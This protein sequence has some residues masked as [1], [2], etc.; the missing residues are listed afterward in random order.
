MKILHLN[1]KAFLAYKDEV[2]IDFTLDNGLYLINGPTGSGKTTIFD[3]IVFAL[4]GQSSGVRGAGSLRSDFAKAKDETYVEL[5][6]EVGGHE[7]YIKRSPSYKREGLKTAK[8]ATAILKIDDHEYVEG[9]KEVN[10]KIIDIL[11]INYEQFKQIVMISQ[12]EFTKLIYSGSDEREKVLR[13]IFNTESLQRLENVLKDKVR[14]YKEEY[15]VSEK[16]L[17]SSL[18]MLSYDDLEDSF[19]PKMLESIYERIEA[20][21]QDLILLEKEYLDKEKDY[22]KASN[23]YTVKSMMNT[24]IKQLEEHH[25]QYQELMLKEEEI[26][27]LK[28]E[29][30][31]LQNISKNQNNILSYTLA[32]QQYQNNKENYN[33]SVNKQKELSK[34]YEEIKQKY[35][36]LDSSRK[37]KDNLYILVN[38]LKQKIDKK[39]EYQ[40]YNTKYRQAKKELDNI[41]EIYTSKYND[42]EKLNVRMQRDQGKVNELPDLLVELKEMD[43]AVEANNQ[44]RVLIHELSELNDHLK[45]EQEKH[46]MLSNAYNKASKI[47]QKSLEEY[48]YQDELYKRQQA[49]I[50]A[51]TLQD[52]TP[53]PV[54]GS[55]EHPS[56]AKL[57]DE[58]LTASQ[59]NKMSKNLQNLLKEKEDA[60][61]QVVLQNQFKT[62]AL[63]QLDILKKQLNIEG[64]LNKRVFIEQLSAITLIIKEGKKKYQKIFEKAEYLKKLKASLKK[65]QVSLENKEKE[66]QALLEELLDKKKE[67]SYLQAKLEE[68][69]DLF[70]E[71][72]EVRYKETLKRYNSL[73]SL[74]NDIE[75]DYLE[76]EKQMIAID[77]SIEHYHELLIQSQDTL[78]TK[79]EEYN[80]YIQECF[81]NEEEFLKYYEMLDQKD[82]KEKMYQE[83]IINKEKLLSNIE[84]LEKETHNNEYTDLTNL[85]EEVNRLKGE[86]NTLQ[87]NYHQKTITID[88][89]TKIYK[90]LK[91]EYNKNKTIHKNYQHY[92]HLS[93]ITSGKNTMKMSFERYVLSF[94]FENI[95]QYANI[96]FSTMSQG[97]YQFVRKTEVKGNAKQGLDLSILDYE[98]GIVRDVQ[99]LS[100]GE[101][102]KAALSLAL[103]L[104]S[105]IQSYVGGIELNTLFVDE[106]F[107]TLDE[108]SLN[109]AIEVLMKLGNN[110][111]IGIISHVSELKEKIDNKI[112]VK[113][114][115]QGSYVQVEFQNN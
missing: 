93:E 99:S 82:D 32:K 1:M 56:K 41:N 45:D 46:Y 100:G 72:L 73:V 80:S 20:S 28:Q 91:K 86:K 50:L 40:E 8:Q 26:I 51:L 58:V 42:K 25:K 23:D 16:V 29:L 94:Y 13:K 4:Y 39:K 63:T 49:G 36:S 31:K 6:F 30:D 62:Q 105:M 14:E 57:V 22:Q 84:M 64:E 15:D 101:S 81:N 38:D 44:K 69:K 71:D 54:C 47:Y 109:Q 103:G 90:T 66:L 104:S 2:K 17:S 10:A 68:N 61:Q 106:G 21:K 70:E 102:F 27:V 35:R 65:D 78:K 108:E 34:E 97:R 74:I 79:Q 98:T 75:K 7:Y 92:L 55:L 107:G 83:Y 114:G 110:K 19:K 87:Q 111:I 48:Q 11:G 96:E 89:D 88:N 115:K 67:V 9:T 3:A 24:K 37:E 85:Q 60:Y 52:N 95:L 112:I 77:K 43:L 33:N 5:T 53:C 76:K 12:G 113:K 18:K 59:L